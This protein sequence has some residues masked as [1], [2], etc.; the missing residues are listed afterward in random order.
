MRVGII[1]KIKFKGSD[2][3][4]IGSTL[5]PR[6]RKEVHIRKLIK[7]NHDNI[8]LQKAF[9]KY[10]IEN[11]IFEKQIDVEASFIRTLEQWYLDF[12]KP[13]Y[14]INKSATTGQPITK[15]NLNNYNSII[16]DYIN[17]NISIEEL[18]SNYKFV[19]SLFYLI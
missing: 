1:Y 11:F 14:N 12:Y 19:K 3:Y 8:I 10:G 7:C 4:Y 9:N 2:N 18:S 6:K 13:K 16:N 15:I 17:T 5:N